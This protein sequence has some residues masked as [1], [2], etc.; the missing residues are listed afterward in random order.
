MRDKDYGSGAKSD[1]E[2]E[3]DDPSL[4]GNVEIHLMRRCACGVAATITIAR[5]S[6]AAL[7]TAISQSRWSEAGRYT[8][9]GLSN[10]TDLIV[11]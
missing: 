2:E 6:S 8:Q 5:V 7:F 1:R 10:S 4:A 9:L 3:A 11:K